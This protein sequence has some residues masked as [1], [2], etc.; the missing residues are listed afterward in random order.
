MKT[1]PLLRHLPFHV[2]LT[3]LTL[4]AG[5]ARAQTATTSKLAS[6][7]QPFVDSHELAGAVVL[8]A[9]KDKVLD[10]EAL[11]W[12]DIATKQ[13]MRTDCL[14]WIASQ[15][16]PIVA[17]ALMMLVDEGKV[18][19]D[20]PVEKYLP[21][22]KEQWLVAERDKEHVLLKKPQH[23]ILVR[24]LLN[25]TSG[26]LYKTPIEQPTLDLL[27]LDQR[28]HAYVMSPLQFEP[29]T[30][31]LYA[32]AGINT[33]A[34]IVELVSGMSYEQFIAERLFVPLDMKDTTFRPNA[35]QLKRLAKS[36]QPNSDG[37]ALEEAPIPQLRYPLDDP[38]RC[39][40]PA[41][42][43]FSTAGDLLNF[44]RM[45]FNGGVFSGKRI[46]SEQAVQQMTSK[47]TGDLPQSYGFGFDTQGGR[48][49]HGGT[50]GTVSS[51]D[52]EHRLITIFMI[53]YAGPPANLNKFVPAFRQA[54]AK[55][56]S[57]SSSQP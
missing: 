10:L 54:V 20:D 57:P 12:S 11:G 29:G 41:G 1:P 15:S 9:D 22:F 31:H 51:I 25:H 7:L 36:Y 6:S 34:R 24:N 40:Q 37:T 26:M 53:Q 55:S 39:I 18:H 42:G 46:L 38:T 45:I 13:S 17:T 35:D 4:T 50:F 49:G 14:F 32:N 8:V 52:Q 56:F 21:E 16:K 5:T 48:I 23:P 30:K 3:L 33:A 27:P 28:M 19:L 43:L 44:Y 2:L 47:Q